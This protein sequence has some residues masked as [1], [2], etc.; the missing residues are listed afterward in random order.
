MNYRRLSPFVL[1]CAAALAVGAGTAHASTVTLRHAALAATSAAGV[2]TQTSSNWAGYAVTDS[3]AAAATGAAPT[4]FSNVAGSWAQPTA[5]CSVGSPTYSAFWVGIGGFADGS[6]ALEQIGTSADC[7]AAGKP[8]YSV[9]YELVPAAPVTIKLKL[10]P[11]DKLS[12]SVAVSGQT[13]SLRIAN[14]TRKTVFTRSLTMASPDLTA[15]EWVAEAPSTCSS[16]GSCRPLPLA[17]FGT[18]T[19]TSSSVTGNGHTGTISDPAWTATA[20][21]LQGTGGGLF[22]GRYA[23][24]VPVADATPGALS[25]DGSSF[26]VSWLQDA[27]TTTSGSPYGGGWGR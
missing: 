19:F 1:A 9:W 20:V 17:N 5:T 15:A 22:S 14:T 18:A 23:S 21:S 3:G 16:N 27:A 2:A 4:T 13:V 12:A 25:T 26:T 6:Q 8:S 24:T 10:A 7:T 11:G